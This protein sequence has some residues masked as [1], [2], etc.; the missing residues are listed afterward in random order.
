[1]IRVQYQLREPLQLYWSEY[2]RLCSNSFKKN[3][4]ETLKALNTFISVFH[5]TCSTWASKG[6]AAHNPS[7]LHLVVAPFGAR[8][9]KQTYS[10]D[11]LQKSWG[12]YQQPC[13][14]SLC[15]ASRKR[16]LKLSRQGNIRAIGQVRVGLR[17]VQNLQLSQG[18]LAMD[19]MALQSPVHMLCLFIPSLLTDDCQLP[20]LEI[21]VDN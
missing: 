9:E 15:H 8:K 5:M 2:A 19:K 3:K 14:V 21:V 18:Q 16:I 11:W 13:S 20:S 4:T 17:T 12:C 1:M 7:I 6:F 10:L